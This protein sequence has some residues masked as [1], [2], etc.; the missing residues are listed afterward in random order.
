MLFQLQKGG[1]EPLSVLLASRLCSIF[2]KKSMSYALPKV[3]IKRQ[4]R[5]IVAETACTNNITE[6]STLK[7]LF[8]VLG[9]GN[10]IYTTFTHNY[11]CLIDSGVIQI[12]THVMQIK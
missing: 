9:R 7:T 5:I 6:R 2:L 12:N 4:S 1:P 3:V 8:E 11:Y 10:A